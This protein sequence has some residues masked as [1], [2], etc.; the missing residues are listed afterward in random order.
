MHH[1]TLEGMGVLSNTKK[2]D[3]VSN[4]VQ[5]SQHVWTIRAA[6][7]VNVDAVSSWTSAIFAKIC[8]K[9]CVHIQGY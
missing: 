9:K 2:T 8:V 3:T 6:V 4:S 7:E 5:G 1:I